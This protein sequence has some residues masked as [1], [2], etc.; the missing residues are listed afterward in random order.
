[1][2]DPR[3]LAEHVVAERAYFGY[4]GKLARELLKAL[5]ERDTL[6]E[7]VANFERYVE[8]EIEPKL[9]ARAEGAEAEYD[10]LR[11][12]LRRADSFIADDGLSDRSAAN[13]ARMV[14][15]AALTDLDAT[16]NPEP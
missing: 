9:L 5:D 15:R 7:Q 1:M 16:S 3:T 8:R 11:E 10:R 6:A 12:A 13:S 4:E 2:T 14:I